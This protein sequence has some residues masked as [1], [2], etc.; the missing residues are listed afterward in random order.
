MAIQKIDTKKELDQITLHK[1]TRLHRNSNLR[2]FARLFRL[3]W[4]PEPG[5]VLQNEWLFQR[6]LFLIDLRSREQ[7]QREWDR[8]VELL[9]VSIC[10]S[11]IFLFILSYL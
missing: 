5:N 9:I 3:F 2:Y 4:M 8:S 6:E 10:F 7:Q 1:R 11:A